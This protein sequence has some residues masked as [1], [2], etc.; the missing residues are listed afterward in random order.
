MTPYPV[1]KLGL[2]NIMW[3]CD[4]LYSQSICR[5]PP[6][7]AWAPPLGSVPLHTSPVLPVCLPDPLHPSHQ[8]DTALLCPHYA[9]RSVPKRPTGLHLSIVRVSLGLLRALRVLTG[10]K[11]VLRTSNL[12]N[13]TLFSRI[14]CNILSNDI[15]TLYI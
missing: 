6:D 10:K 13:T 8:D 4:Q 12:W 9:A 1:H 5:V 15:E 3:P 14:S 11:E 2:S 7:R